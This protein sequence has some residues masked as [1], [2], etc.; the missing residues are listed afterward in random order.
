MP[1]SFGAGDI[2]L[3][4][5]ATAGSGHEDAAFG[6]REDF[7]GIG[8]GGERVGVDFFFVELVVGVGEGDESFGA[9]ERSGECVGEQVSERRVGESVEVKDT[10]VGFE[11]A[12]VEIPSEAV[13]SGIF[14]D[15]KIRIGFDLSLFEDGESG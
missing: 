2:V 6:T 1:P 15:K 4:D 14:M 11:V 5:D 12:F 10:E 9:S 3:G 7:G 8:G 13:E